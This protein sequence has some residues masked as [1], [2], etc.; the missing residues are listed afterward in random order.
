MLKFSISISIEQKIEIEI[1]IDININIDINIDID[2]LLQCIYC[3]FCKILTPY[4]TV[5]YIQ[6]CTSGR[7]RQ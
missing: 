2:I 6:Y 1:E 5:L 3:K 4:S 7:R